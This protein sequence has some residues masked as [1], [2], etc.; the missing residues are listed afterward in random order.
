M[1]TLYV[2]YF[3]LQEPLVQTQVLPYLRELSRDVAEVNLVTFEPKDSLTQQEAQKL[4]L[5]VRA[6]GIEWFSLPYHKRPS[7]LGTAY[8]I[9]AGAWFLV[10]F[11]RR[12]RIDVV[13]ARSHVPMAMALLAQH[14]GASYR[15]IFDI[16]GLMAEEY[17]DAGIW[18]ENSLPF[19]AVKRVERA[20]ILRADQVV[21]LTQRFRN[22]LVANELKPMEQIE[23][24]PCC[25]DLSRLENG[26]HEN[27][28]SHADR[29]EVIYAGS[30]TGLYLL[31]EM[32]RFFLEVQ[33][34]RPH[35]FL[36]VLTFSSPTDAGQ[37][38]R[39]IGLTP[40]DFWIG[41][42][43]PAEVPDYLRR[44]HLGLSFRKRSFSQIAASP[45]KIP[46]YLAAGL[47]VVCTDGVGDTEF[48]EQKGVGVVVRD[49]NQQSYSEAVERI[50]LLLENPVVRECCIRTARAH[51]DLETVGAVGYAN[52]YRRISETL[53]S[54]QRSSA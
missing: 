44:A 54:A 1:K 16:R 4:R 45:T 33:K 10:R 46:E 22:W 5:S 18:A 13:H 39:G 14:L 28:R 49:L 6:E 9:I 24:I 2:C 53:A 7:L 25:V 23:V 30:V 12:K 35:A 43:S 3:G 15:L 21:V 50:L 40:E 42:V 36:R 29:F 11:G 48:L 26:N 41:T 38:L 27:G 17:G 8:D 32:G 52:V 20:G 31:E 51:F 34:R 47:P 37:V 19:R